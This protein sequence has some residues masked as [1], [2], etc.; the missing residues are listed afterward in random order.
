MNTTRSTVK[1]ELASRPDVIAFL[2]SNRSLGEIF[3]LPGPVS[4]ERLKTYRKAYFGIGHTDCYKLNL[5]NNNQLYLKMEYK[6]AMGNNHYARFWVIHLF[7][8]ELLGLIVPGKTKILEVT[9]GSSG[10]ALSMA[11]EVLGYDVT[12]LVPDILPENRVM[13]MMRNTTTIIPVKGYINDCVLKLR[14][15]LREADYYPTNHSEEQADVITDVFRRIG[16]EIATEIPVPIDYACLAMGNGTSTIGISHALK[17]V[18]PAT[19][20]IAYRPDFEN[21]PEEIVFGLIAANIDCRHVPLAMRQIDELK[22]T[23]GTDL[24]ALRRAYRH[25]TEIK[26]LGMSS[27][28][29]IYLATELAK[30]VEGKKIVTLGYD[31]I[32]RY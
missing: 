1:R 3:S 32:D 12:I 16:H 29:G 2:A 11:C 7:I 9:S 5:P 22:Y 18:N 26:N 17:A 31:K 28:Y 20:V 4:A 8:S 24:E 30:V 23:T 25:D 14:E 27:L 10:I 19:H 6:N 13:P 15:M 21:H